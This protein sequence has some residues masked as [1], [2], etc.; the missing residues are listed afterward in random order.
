MTVALMPSLCALCVLCGEKLFRS[1]FQRLGQRIVQRG[2][3]GR[4]DL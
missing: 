4:F 1:S 3:V 2:V